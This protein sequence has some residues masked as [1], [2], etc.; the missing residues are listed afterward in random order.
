M[1]VP[2]GAARRINHVDMKSLALI[3]EEVCIANTANRDVIYVII[4]HVCVCVL[5]RLAKIAIAAKVIS[6]IRC[7]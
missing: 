6:I 5:E 3:D 7:I 2:N 1:S 4:A